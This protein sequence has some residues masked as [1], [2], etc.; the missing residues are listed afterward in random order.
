MFCP[1]FGACGLEHLQ[2]EKSAY[3]ASPVEL[4]RE[5]TDIYLRS[6]PVVLA[7]SKLVFLGSRK[8]FQERNGTNRASDP[9]TTVAIG[10]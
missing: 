9:L 2:R 3:V 10:E 6:L 4:K 1:F 7:Q 5:R 8:S